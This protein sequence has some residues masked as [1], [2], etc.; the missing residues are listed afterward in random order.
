MLTTP[1]LAHRCPQLGGAF[2][3]TT[4]PMNTNAIK[5]LL[6]RPKETK[7]YA[8]GLTWVASIN[9]DAWFCQHIPRYKDLFAIAGRVIP[10]SNGRD[11]QDE[12][13]D[14]PQYLIKFIG[15]FRDVDHLPA[16]LIPKFQVGRLVPP[17]VI[18]RAFNVPA[19][20]R[21]FNPTTR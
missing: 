7:A 19:M 14:A 6:T 20:P 12:N 3:H 18:A 13:R 8:R 17:A 10:A 2:F 4:S 16:N 15:R 21:D 1:E 9:Q 5:E 11:E